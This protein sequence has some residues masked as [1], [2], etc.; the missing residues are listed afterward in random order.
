MKVYVNLK[1]CDDV[2]VLD[3]FKN[4]D[5]VSVQELLDKIGELSSEVER[6]Q[7]SLDELKRDYEDLEDDLEDNYIHRPMSHYTGDSYDDR[8]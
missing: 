3:E 7:E 6:L 1:E 5:L 2:Y 8:F 4:Q